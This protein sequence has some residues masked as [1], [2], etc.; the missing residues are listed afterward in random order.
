MSDQ[1]FDFH[2]ESLLTLLS[3]LHEHADEF[4]AFVDR[5]LGGLESLH[6][7]L[8]R[9]ESSLRSE[10]ERLTDELSETESLLVLGDEE[11]KTLEASLAEA[12]QKQ[13]DA[14]RELETQQ[15]QVEQWETRCSEL[16]G[17]LAE[18]QAQVSAKK[19]QGDSDQELQEELALLR[20][21]LQLQS[22]LLAERSIDPAEAFGADSDEDLDPV[23]DSV[24]AQFA[25]FKPSESRR[26]A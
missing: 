23:L 3:Q 24:I 20:E 21:A 16:E 2:R 15:A 4:E 1:Q 17:Q 7:K 9:F 11:R 25:Q 5:E 19:Q 6:S 22:E 10:R 14:Q 8:R 13:E 18:L 12:R 26:S